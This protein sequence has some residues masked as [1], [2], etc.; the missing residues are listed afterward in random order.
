MIGKICGGIMKTKRIKSLKD[1][2]FKEILAF[3]LLP[4]GLLT[5][6]TTIGTAYNIFLTDVIKLAP[7]AVGIVL[8][9]TKVWDAIN[10]PMMG[11]FVDKTRTKYGKCRPYL[12]WAVIPAVLATAM[13]FAPINFGQTGNT[14]YCF[15][16]YIIF[17]TAYTAIDIPYQGLT[18]LVFPENDKR[19]KAISFSNILGSIG[20][21][22][23]QV[24][25]FVFVGALGGGND[26]QGFFLT[27]LMLA[28]LAGAFIAAS[29]F[30]IKEK[31]YI[32][33]KRTP[34]FKGLKAV[35]KDKKWLF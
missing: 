34:F 6:S 12:I 21:I 26:K 14:V 33:P 25:F 19:V 16:A 10:D 28:M 15:I 23:P 31:V 4:F 18:P 5:I 29:F 7:A 30:G 20:T 32:P 27:A 22:I 17:Y 1:A 8:S 11:F 9:G 24:L 2:S 35:F 3:S 13:L